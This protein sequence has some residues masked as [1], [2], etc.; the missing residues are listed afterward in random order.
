[1]SNSTVEV[2]RGMPA[3]EEIA[4]SAYRAYAAS[5]GN[6]NFR[7]EPMPAFDDLPT[8]IQT[9]WEAAVMQASL[10]LE[11]RPGDALPDES[12]WAGWLPPRFTGPEDRPPDA[13]PPDDITPGTR[14]LVVSPSDPACP[15][16]IVWGVGRVVKRAG[17]R[18]EVKFD[19]GSGGIF[20]NA[21]IRREPDTWKL[22]AERL[23]AAGW[24]VNYAPAFHGLPPFLW[25]SPDGLSGSEY[26]SSHPDSPPEAVM[27]E[28]CRRGDVYFTH[29]G[30]S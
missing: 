6:K 14:T 16:E 11:C 30:P 9:A 17:G 5:T 7:G 25:R 15:R 13:I 22:V 19:N 3:F 24:V 28:A 12:R 10:C 2:V 27:K 26:R 20:P 1:M 8:G 23:R 29:L 18:T 21:C 4:A